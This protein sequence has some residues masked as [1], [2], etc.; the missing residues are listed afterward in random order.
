[1]VKKIQSRGKRSPRRMHMRK[2]PSSGHDGL[3]YYNQ[4]QGFSEDSIE[5]QLNHAVPQATYL[6]SQTN[7]IPWWRAGWYYPYAWPENDVPVYFDR[8]A[9]TEE[10]QRPA[11]HSRQHQQDSLVEGY[12]YAEQLVYYPTEEEHIRAAGYEADV[13]YDGA[14]YYSSCQEHVA[15]HPNIP[16]AVEVSGT[17]YYSPYPS[18]P[19][20]EEGEPGKGYIEGYHDPELELMTS[21]WWRLFGATT[22][23]MLVLNRV[24]AEMAAQVEATHQSE[25]REGCETGEQKDEWSAARYFAPYRGSEEE[26]CT[27]CEAERMERVD[28]P[29]E[30][31]NCAMAR[32]SSEQVKM[33]MLMKEC[34]GRDDWECDFCGVECFC[35][36]VGCD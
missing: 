7:A 2:R 13:R 9:V 15:P 33:A 36:T 32:R 1:M 18:P 24:N 34:K 29:L 23:E 35:W 6:D 31:L 3:V 21:D 17:T 14:T 22:R 26:A 27:G 28:R 16:G 10:I 5:R 12:A 19:A 30:I 8:F 25:V 20:S 11:S 4:W